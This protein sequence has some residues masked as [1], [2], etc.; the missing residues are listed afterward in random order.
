LYRG[1]KSDHV[2]IDVLF[3]VKIDTLVKQGSNGIFHVEFYP[4][5]IGKKTKVIKTLVVEVGRRFPFSAHSAEF[6]V[7]GL[8]GI[9]NL[10]VHRISCAGCVRVYSQPLDAPDTEGKIRAV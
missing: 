6:K 3:R 10:N 5:A 8:D 4:V 9:G 1:G 2:K 7:V